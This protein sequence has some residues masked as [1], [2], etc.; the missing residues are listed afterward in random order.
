MAD[1]GKAVTISAAPMRAFVTSQGK[2][3]TNSE[4]LGIIVRHLKGV[5]TAAEELQ[6]RLER[7]EKK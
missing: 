1:Q 5:I 4:L 6:A 3:Q 2:E 7:E